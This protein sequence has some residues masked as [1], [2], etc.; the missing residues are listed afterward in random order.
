MLH[1]TMGVF[2]NLMAD[3]Q[4]RIIFKE[5]DGIFKLIRI[6]QI[7]GE[8]DWSLSMLTCQVIWNYCIDSTNLHEVFE[9]TEI[10]ELLCILAEYLGIITNFFLTL[11]S[12]RH[13]FHIVLDEEKL[14]GITDSHENLE[15]FAS[16][17]YMLWDE[18]ANVATNLL[19]KIESFLDNIEPLE[20]T[21][22]SDE[23]D[24]C[25]PQNKENLSFT[26]W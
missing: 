6:L 17:E 8:L 24:L 13:A 21:S 14:F 7:Y 26:K 18:F 2:V 5:N 23:E 19:E 22:Y 12:S 25:V 4:T 10:E 16:Q 3:F 20:I 1:T 9:G 11:K 15:V